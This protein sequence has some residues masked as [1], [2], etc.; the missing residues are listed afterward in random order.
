MSGI[1]WIII[2]VL[3]IIGW[4]IVEFLEHR[5]KMAELSEKQSNNEGFTELQNQVERLRKRVEN[6]ETIAVETSSDFKHDTDLSDS[7]KQ[8]TL[9]DDRDDYE[10]RVASRAG[11]KRK[12]K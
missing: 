1:T 3:G 5:T 9:D 11:Q 12:S 10:S 2:P 8:I 6:L 4:M 7:P